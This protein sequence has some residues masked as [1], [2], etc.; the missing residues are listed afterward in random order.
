MDNLTP[1]NHLRRATRHL[2]RRAVERRRRLN[3]S[4]RALQRHLAH[5]PTTPALRSEME[6]QLAAQLQELRALN[7]ILGGRHV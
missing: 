2:A 7:A 5:T 6:Q 4:T 3:S 1:S